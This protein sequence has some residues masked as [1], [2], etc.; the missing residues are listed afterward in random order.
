MHPIAFQIGSFTIY[1]YGVLVALGFWIGLWN[2]SRRGLRSGLNPEYI[3]DAGVWI[4]LGTIVGARAL[5]VITFWKT[6]FAGQPL[7]EIFM[8]HHGG[9]VFYGG[10][11]GASLATV[12]Y[13]SYKKIP[14]W[15]F[16]DVFA[17]GVALGYVPGRL[18][19]VMNGCCYGRATDLPWAIHFPADHE[20]HG[21]GVHPTQIYD[22]LLNLALFLALAWLYP[23]KKFD[24]QVFAA[25]LMGY[26]V[27]RSTVEFF[28]GDYASYWGGWATQAHLISL[29]IFAAGLFLFWRL[30]RP[31]PAPNRATTHP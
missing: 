20:T 16:G 4:V 29:G 9:L 3:W 27:T 12:G 7:S 13:L 24:G 22:S 19:C 30:P 2:A 23:R 21:A 31:L 26:A 17:P 6:K 8:V 5:F 25:Y 11:I 10:L 18:G 14:L 1:W 15:K 28:R